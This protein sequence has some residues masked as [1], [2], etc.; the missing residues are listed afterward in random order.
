MKKNGFTLIELLAVVS[1]MALLAIIM[2]PKVLEQVK[3]KEEDIDD[4]KV[5][6][7]ES[8]ADTYIAEN[9]NDYPKKEGNV[10]CISVDTLVSDNKVLVDISDIKN[11]GRIIVK[12]KV[13]NDRYIYSL[14]K[15]NKCTVK[16]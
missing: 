10:Y 12:V 6:L 3:Q 14:V 13:S 9:L 8:A 4:A 5:A 11:S 15:E 16:N 1:I 2:I 7:I